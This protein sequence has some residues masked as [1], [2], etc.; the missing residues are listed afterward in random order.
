[1]RLRGEGIGVAGGSDGSTGGVTC[2]F[3]GP[4]KRGNAFSSQT[5][6]VFTIS[7]CLSV[8][9]LELEGAFLLHCRGIF[10]F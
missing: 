4:P 3:R 1:M 5:R 10:H 6:T 9:L 8:N 2:L 7:S